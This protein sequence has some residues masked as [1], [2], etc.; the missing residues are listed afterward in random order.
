MRE[1]VGLESVCHLSTE[2][3]IIHYSPTRLTS[4]TE[5]SMQQLAELPLAVSENESE[6]WCESI[7]YDTAPPRISSLT[8]SSLSLSTVVLDSSIFAVSVGM[9]STKS[10]F[11]LQLYYMSPLL[12]RVSH[13]C[14]CSYRMAVI[15]ILEIS[16]KQR[17]CQRTK[18]DGRVD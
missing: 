12:R 17:H 1:R 18:A 5:L 7:L 9:S 15:S 2:S 4:F 13:V 14:E 3:E 16:T 6:R 10:V 8:S 11:K